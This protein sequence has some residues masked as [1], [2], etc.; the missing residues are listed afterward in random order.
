MRGRV[1]WFN[2]AKG[3]GFIS[4]SSGDDVFV[5]YTAIATQGFRTLKQSTV[6]EFEV[7][8]T[9]KGLQATHVRD[10]GADGMIAGASGGETKISREQ[11]E[12]PPATREFSPSDSPPEEKEKSA[13]KRR[14]RRRRSRGSAGTTRGE[15][16]TKIEPPRSPAVSASDDTE[17]WR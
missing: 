11:G 10:L 14:N 15:A 8:T 2:N 12:K 7:V 17:W 3:Y 13:L 9:S 4:A 16:P 6:V 5:H 1:K